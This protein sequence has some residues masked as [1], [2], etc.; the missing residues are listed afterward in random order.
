M[1]SGGFDE[2]VHDYLEDDAA[3]AEFLVVDSG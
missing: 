3:D 1:R 2:E